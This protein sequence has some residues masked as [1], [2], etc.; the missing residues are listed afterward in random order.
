MHSRHGGESSAAQVF[1]RAFPRLVFT[2]LEC[3]CACN[4]AIDVSLSP[5]HALGIARS[6]ATIKIFMVDDRGS[7]ADNDSK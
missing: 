2:I 3:R 5:G 6:L 1:L 7:D 4:S